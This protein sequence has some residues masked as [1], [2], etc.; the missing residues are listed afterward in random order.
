MAVSRGGDTQVLP[1]VETACAL[2][3]DGDAPSLPVPLFTPDGS[4][5]VRNIC[6]TC[7]AAVLN[8]SLQ[9]LGAAG[10]Q[11][12]DTVLNMQPSRPRA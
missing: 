10:H 7:L 9:L 8:V 4:M 2:C 3:G 12:A 6:R 1:L 5:R 11:T